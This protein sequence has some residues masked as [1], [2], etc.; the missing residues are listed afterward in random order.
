MWQND[1]LYWGTLLKRICEMCSTLQLIQGRFKKK[2]SF[3]YTK[4]ILKET[5]YNKTPLAR[6]LLLI[7]LRSAASVFFT[8]RRRSSLPEIWTVDV[9]YPSWETRG[10]RRLVRGKKGSGQ[11]VL[12]EYLEFFPWDRQWYKDAYYSGGRLRQ[13]TVFNE[14][15]LFW[16]A[17]WLVSISTIIS[18]IVFYYL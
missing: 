5:G 2:V 10:S 11:K 12:N 15:H 18:N 13:M 14:G 17:G 4:I 9:F 7:V 16:I 3:G 1:R 6:N 8:S